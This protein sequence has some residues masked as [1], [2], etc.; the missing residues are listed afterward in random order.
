MFLLLLLMLNLN[1]SRLGLNYVWLLLGLLLLPAVAIFHGLRLHHHANILVVG[2][3]MSGLVVVMYWN[4]FV[5]LLRSRLHTNLLFSHHVQETI[6]AIEK[7][8][9]TPNDEE[10]PTKEGH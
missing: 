2:V 5:L 3:D 8:G 6:F 7:E 4:S 1:I 10:R 9:R